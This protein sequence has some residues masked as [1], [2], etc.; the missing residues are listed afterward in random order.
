M[1]G[2][3]YSILFSLE[4]LILPP[5][6]F[7]RAFAKTIFLLVGTSKKVSAN[8]ISYLTYDNSK[9]FHEYHFRVHSEKY[10]SETIP[11]DLCRNQ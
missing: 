9:S 2:G 3:F 4:I 10:V 5:A 8:N 6:S 1:S 11:R 7:R